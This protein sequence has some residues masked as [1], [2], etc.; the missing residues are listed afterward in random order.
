V[1]VQ[2]L[3]EREVLGFSPEEVER[4]ILTVAGRELRSITWWG[5]ILGALVGG[6]QS[7]LSLLVP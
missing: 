3:V 4:V 1:D 5:G 7:A 2:G 6:L